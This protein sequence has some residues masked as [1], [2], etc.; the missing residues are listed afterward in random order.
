MTDLILLL[1]LVTNF[2]TVILWRYQLGQ[3]GSR[4]SLWILATIAC[5]LLSTWLFSIPYVWTRA[6]FIS[7]GVLGLSGWILVFAYPLWSKKVPAKKTS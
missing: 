7:L 1:A 6:P 4:R 2:I 5:F 3:Q